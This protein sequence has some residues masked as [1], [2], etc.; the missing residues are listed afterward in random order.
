[1]GKKF[2]RLAKHPTSVL[3]IRTDGEFQYVLKVLM[4]SEIFQT[5][6]EVIYQ[7]IY[8]LANR[9]GIK[10]SLGGLYGTLPEFDRESD[11]GNIAIPMKKPK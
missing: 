5:Q 1:M 7:A 8:E 2:N 11:L 4:G 10:T 3:S 9:H 6:S